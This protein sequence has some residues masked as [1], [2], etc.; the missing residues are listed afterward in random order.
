MNWRHEFDETRALLSGHFRLSSGLH[1][2]RYL[3]CAL[4][5]Q[6][7]ERARRIGDALGELLGSFEPSVV[8]GPA[9]GGVIV[10]YETA[11]ALGVRSVFTERKD[12][13]MQLRRGF[14]FTPGERA[15]VVEDVFTTGK[16]TRE[17]IAAIG[18]QGARVVAAGSIVDRGLPP[19]ALAV[20][21]RSLLVVDAPAWPENACPLCAEGF[22][23]EAPGSR[24]LNA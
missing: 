22:P 4:I 9:L 11:R 12:G 18:Q 13:V 6:W 10:G 8:V 17:T 3:Q 21:W 2:D 1:S 24:T 23:L 15:V 7:P 14:S 20:P 19:D 16:S 5:L